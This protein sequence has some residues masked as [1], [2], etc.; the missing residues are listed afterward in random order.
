MKISEIEHKTLMNQV[1]INE[2]DIRITD[3]KKNI[4]NLRRLKW[5]L[6]M[7]IEDNDKKI[8]EIDFNKFH[9]IVKNTLKNK[10]K[11]NLLKH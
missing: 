11:C 2:I 5:Q 1:K 4:E 9:N 10:K 3:L 6:I 7:E 8:L